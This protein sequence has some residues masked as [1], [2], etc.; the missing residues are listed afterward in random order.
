[1]AFGETVTMDEFDMAID[2]LKTGKV[3]ILPN[4]TKIDDFNILQGVVEDLETTY[5]DYEIE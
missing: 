1:M 2:Y 5:E 3:P 4:N